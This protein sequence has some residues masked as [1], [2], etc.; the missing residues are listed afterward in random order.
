MISSVAGVICCMIALISVGVIV[1][2]RLAFGD[3]VAG[4]ASLA[5]IITLLGGLQLLCMGI[6][7]QYLAK[8]YM[9]TKK[10]P[11][12]IISETNREGDE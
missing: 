7:G 4:W 1:V 5:C 12:Y 10:R 11:I 2:R 8:T 3:P 6:I 9:E